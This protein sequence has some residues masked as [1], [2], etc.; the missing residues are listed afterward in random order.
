M[1]VGVSPVF[2]RIGFARSDYE[3]YRNELALADLVEPLG[4]DSIWTTEHHFTDYEM[5]P[6]PLQ[7]LTYMAGRTKRIRL[8]TM[9]VVIPWHDPLRV[10]E[11]ISVLENLSGGRM[12]LGIGRGLGRV[13]F[14]G[15]R[16]PMDKSRPIFNEHAENI[17]NSLESGYFESDGDWSKVPRRAL[18][19]APFDSFQGRT[20]I[21]GISPETVP[22][23]VKHGA[24]MLVIPSKSWGEVTGDLK[25]FEETWSAERPTDPRPRPLAVAFTYVDKD[26]K[27][28]AD[29]AGSHIGAY[30]NSVLDHYEIRQTRFDQVAG[31][32]HYKGMSDAANAD[33]DQVVRNFVDQMM[34]GTP[35]QVL[36][37]IDWLRA[38]LDISTLICHFSFTGMPYELADRSM[39]LFAEEVLP[40]LHSWGV[41][42]HVKPASERA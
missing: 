6:S 33:A 20:F 35:E 15:F 31:Y 14:E 21:A 3:V 37:K 41:A 25:R 16:V 39:R 28:A 22:L 38:T 12:I 42:S 40:V 1:K 9:V 29:I 2:Q 8:G 17:L 18:R 5:I 10:A 7:F 26:A 27:R 23:A 13:E 32:S 30:W 34:W 4:F 19:P 24:G 36:E 11:E